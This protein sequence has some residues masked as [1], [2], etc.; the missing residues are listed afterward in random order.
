MALRY[1]GR[2]SIFEYNGKRYTR[3]P[4]GDEGDL[5]KPIPGLTRLEATHL[6]ETSRLHSFEEGGEDLEEKLTKPSTDSGAVT[7]T[8][9]EP[10]K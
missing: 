10:K 8:V 1:T 9:A 7:A 4:V 3:N 6:V 5:N 2:A